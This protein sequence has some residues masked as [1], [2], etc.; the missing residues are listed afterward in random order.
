[1]SYLFSPKVDFIDQNM[2]AAAR[3]RSSTPLTLF[4]H[5]NQYGTNPFKFDTLTAGTGTIT[6]P[7]SANTSAT[8][9]STGGTA[10]GAQAVRASRAYMHYETGKSLFVGCSFAFGTGAT[11]CSQRAGYYDANNGV[12]IQQIGTA[13]SI[14]VVTSSS[15][16]AVTTTIAQASWN[17][18]QFTGSGPSGQ[19]LNA[20]A[21]QN[22]RFDFIGNSSIR[23]YLYANGRYWLIHVI[24][25]QNNGALATPVTANLTVRCEVVNTATASA[26]CSMNVY[27]QS[28]MAEGSENPFYSSTFSAGT[29]ITTVT[30][31]A[32]RPLCSIRAN[33][34]G[35]HS[36][37]NY[38]Q[39]VL[40]QVS[41]YTAGTI[42]LE[43]VYNATLT[44]AAFASVNAASLAQFDTAATALSGGITVGSEFL[45]ASGG[46]L[47]TPSA[48]SLAGISLQFPLV[49]SSL[50]NTQDTITVAITPIG[51][52]EATAANL[53]W[54][55][56]W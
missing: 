56:I 35:M 23:C 39:M 53:T 36:I 41:A 29:G 25:N 9:L 8:V 16:S 42:F 2:D 34:V 50:Q 38:G 30:P 31:T 11:G 28:V 20:T 6:E 45:S 27:N 40:T 5:S 3:L 24:E 10:S 21:P 44:G 52:G 37:R 48:S 18:D 26:T 12:Y 51:T 43:V 46:L 22:V 49:Y 33:T 54:N 32:R 1:M 19:T 17:I 4:E 55:E 15:G 47:S 13:V 7:A 14:A